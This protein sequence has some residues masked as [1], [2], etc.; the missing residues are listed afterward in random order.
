MNTFKFKKKRKSDPSQPVN[1]HGANHR[2]TRTWYVPLSLATLLST[3]FAGFL[4]KI[5]E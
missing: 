2:L 3:W 1:L 5:W 4:A